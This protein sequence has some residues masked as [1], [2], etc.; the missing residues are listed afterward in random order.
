MYFLK[1]LLFII[2]FIYNKCKKKNV[3]QMNIEMQIVN[4]LIYN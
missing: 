3:E 4:P 1:K 2:F